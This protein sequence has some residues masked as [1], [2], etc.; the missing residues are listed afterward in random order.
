[1]H[2]AA[3]VVLEQEA[4]QLVAKGV[5]EIDTQWIEVEKNE[6]IRVGTERAGGAE[7]V[8]MK[9]KSRLVAVGNQ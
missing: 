8:P 3:D 2:A 9:L 7:P 1:M 4:V 5:E 6:H